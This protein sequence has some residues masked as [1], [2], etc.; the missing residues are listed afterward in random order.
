MCGTPIHEGQAAPFSGVL[1][2]VELAASLGTK[3]EFCAR[4]IKA[5]VDHAGRL[6]NLELVNQQK[7]H[8]I[9]QEAWQQK[10]KLL[11]GELESK[12]SIFRE[13]WFVATVSV[14]LTL[15]VVGVAAYGLGVVGN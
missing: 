7:L 2:T 11:L 8:K 3:A 9:D 5:E 4:R 13:P 10:E 15:G 14:V 6:A 1:L 12:H